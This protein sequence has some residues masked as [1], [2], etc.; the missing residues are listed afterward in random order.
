M[1][2]IRWIVAVL[3]AFALGIGATLLML[4]HSVPTSPASP[5][6]EKPVLYWYDPMVPQQ[7]FDAPGKSPYM[8]MQLLPKYA[9]DANADDGSVRIDPRQVQN[10]GVRSAKVE[11]GPLTRNIRTT[12]ALAF[13]ERAMVVVQSR[14]AG[15]VDKLW[16]R[17]PLTSVKRGEP[18]LSVIAPDWTAAQEEYLSLRQA[19][20]AGLDTLRAAARRRL[21]LIGM[22]EAQIRDVERA[23]RAQERI[24]INAPRDGVVTELNAREGASVA[25]GAPLLTLNG[26]ETVWMNAAIAEVDS[27]S[28][29]AGA[30]VKATLAAFPGESFDGKVEALLPDLDPVTRTQKARIVLPNPH[31]RLAPGMFASIQ[32]MPPD[33]GATSLLIPEEALITTGMRDVVIV[34]EGKGRF[35]AQE[36]RSGEHAG[37]KVAIS[38]GLHEGDNVVL[39]GQFL[40]DSEASLIGALSRLNTT[41]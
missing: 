6:S 20:T 41:P 11:R 31:A 7:H 1:N 35:R 37:G 39:S 32:I 22:E 30:T 3:F 8:D 16:V 14:V 5:S 2:N 33:S 29:V 12:G 17:A 15:I 40:I 13:D 9:T 23:G 25:T 4:R 21:L 26:L 27:A 19:K 18:L 36:V 34:D 28:I 38:N 24:T 10:L